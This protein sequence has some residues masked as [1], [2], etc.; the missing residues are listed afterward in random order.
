[1]IKRFPKPSPSPQ[2]ADKILSSASERKSLTSRI[3]DSWGLKVRRNF[4]VPIWPMQALGHPTQMG[5]KRG[6]KA[7]GMFGMSFSMIFS[8]IIII[9]IIATAIYAITKFAGLGNCAQIGLFFDDFQDEIDKAWTSGIYSDTFEIDL[10]AKIE[11]ICFDTD[12]TLSLIPSEKACDGDLS[13]K[14]LKHVNVT[15]NF[16]KV[17]EDEN[18]I[19]LKKGPRDNLVF[20]TRI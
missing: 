20:L 14:T 2:Q 1:M 9:A 6:R 7:Q 5:I 11:E 18:T 17:L 10:P 16:C 15:N 8:I 4:D 19:K 12:S 13:F 3:K